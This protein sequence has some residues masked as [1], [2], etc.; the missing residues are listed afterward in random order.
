MFFEVIAY[1]NVPAEAAAYF[2]GIIDTVCY[3]SVK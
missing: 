1:H 2:D 3:I